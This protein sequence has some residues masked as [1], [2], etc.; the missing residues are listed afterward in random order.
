MTQSIEF[1]TDGAP[2]RIEVT[3]DAAVV[4]ATMREGVLQ[5]VAFNG[6]GSTTFDALRAVL[7]VRARVL[8]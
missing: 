1:T 4:R 7:E 5:N 6:Y 2:Y 3:H 8:A